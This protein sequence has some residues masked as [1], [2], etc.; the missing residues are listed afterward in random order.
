MQGSNDH[1]RPLDATS[2]EDQVR[3][4]ISQQLRRLRP[5]IADRFGVERIEL[6]G[7]AARDALRGES[8]IDVLVS[9]RGPATLDG[10]F[11]LKGFLE[12]ALGHPVDRVTERALKPLARVSVERDLI[13][14]SVTGSSS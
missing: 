1:L 2:V 13:P 8:D 14:C 5:E 6:L 9:F 11:E 12:E 7:S 4:S 10:Y 3:E